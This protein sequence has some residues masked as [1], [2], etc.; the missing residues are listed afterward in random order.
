MTPN[1]GVS[2]SVGPTIGEQ[3]INVGA[4]PYFPGAWP[5]DDG[6]GK[7]QEVVKITSLDQ[8]R[9]DFVNEAEFGELKRVDGWNAEKSVRLFAE[10]GVFP[11]IIYNEMKAT[12]KD[13][14]VDE[15]VAFYDL[16]EAVAPQLGDL[17]IT[18]YTVPASGKKFYYSITLDTTFPVVEIFSDAAMTNKLCGGTGTATSPWTVTLAE[19]ASSGVSG[20]C[21][22]TS[23]SLIEES[24]IINLYNSGQLANKY[25]IQGA[26]DTGYPGISVTA[27]TY[28]TDYTLERLAGYTEITKVVDGTA[29]LTI[30]YSYMVP[31]TIDLARKKLAIDAVDECGTAT[32]ISIAQFP[33]IIPLTGWGWKKATDEA[34]DHVVDVR[35]YMVDKKALNDFLDVSSTYDLDETDFNATTKTSIDALLD[36]KSTLAG[37]IRCRCFSGSYGTETEHLQSDWNLLVW[38]RL[39]EANGQFPGFVASNQAGMSGFVPDNEYLQSH[40]IPQQL[41]DYGISC[42]ALSF[43]KLWGAWGVDTSIVNG[44]PGANDYALESES[45]NDINQFVLRKVAIDTWIKRTDKP[46]TASGIE[47]MVMTWNA[48]F[49]SLV[50]TGRLIYGRIEF[51]ESDQTDLTQVVV[52]RLIVTGPIIQKQTEVILNVDLTKINFGG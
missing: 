9:T 16:N 11:F 43:A 51:R 42:A 46:L 6:I 22:V 36:D 31:T 18:G 8:Y 13:D 40:T 24:G 7:S 4:V 25:A 29:P 47:D 5:V 30:S 35:N 3:P 52:Y 21:I 2:T 34:T 14:V 33:F 37:N 26:A 20:T 10:K 23:V 39:F 17:D 15:S 28:E 38:L 49:A 32:N 44:T 19:E 12:D 48:W 45:Q 50:S 1:Y 27:K 41:R